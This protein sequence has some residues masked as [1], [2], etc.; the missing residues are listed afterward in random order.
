MS[1]ET[2]RMEEKR[3]EVSSHL[4]GEGSVT[5]EQTRAA[6]LYVEMGRNHVSSAAQ[7]EALT[8]NPSLSPLG[9][10]GNLSTD[11]SICR[12]SSAESLFLRFKPRSFRVSWAFP[13]QCRSQPSTYKPSSWFTSP[14]PPLK[15]LQ[16]PSQ[17]VGIIH[18]CN[19]HSHKGLPLS[20]QISWWKTYSTCPE[21]TELFLILNGLNNLLKSI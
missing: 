21:D 8:G 3:T 20:A 14:L 2:P 15:S 9:G 5:R 16:K 17:I 10:Q 4:P 7:D 13:T 6:V 1:T 12:N 19:R 11:S 18:I